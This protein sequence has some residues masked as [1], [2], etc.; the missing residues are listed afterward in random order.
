MG[1]DEIRYPRLASVVVV[2]ENLVWSWFLSSL[3]VKLCPTKV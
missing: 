2:E 3:R 1:W